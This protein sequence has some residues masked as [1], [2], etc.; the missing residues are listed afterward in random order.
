MPVTPT[1]P[2]VYIQEIDSGSRVVTGVPTSI[3]AFVGRAE[4]GAANEP[5]TV[6]DYGDFETTFGGLTIDM[7][8][9]YAVKDFFENGGSQAIVIRVCAG[10][11]LEA[12]ASLDFAT[13]DPNYTLTARVKGA[14]GNSLKLKIDTVKNPDATLPATYHAT[15]SLG[16]MTLA[17]TKNAPP[18]DGSKADDGPGL[19]PFAIPMWLTDQNDLIST[20]GSIAPEALPDVIK[21]N[22][23]QDLTFTGG[24]DDVGGTPAKF[25]AGEL[26]LDAMKG[27][28]V[29]ELELSLTTGSDPKQFVLTADHPILTAPIQLTFASWDELKKKL[30]DTTVLSLATP[31]SVALPF[32]PPTI[33]LPGAAATPA[34]APA[35]PGKSITLTRIPDGQGASKS[36]LVVGMGELVL[37]S[38]SPGAW[39]NSYGVYFDKKNITLD[40]ALRYADYGI[41][42]SIDD[43]WNVNVVEVKGGKPHPVAETIG[44]CYL[45]PQDAPC[46]ID[47]MLARQSSYLRSAPPI[48]A[49]AAV[50]LLID[51]TQVG[52]LMNDGKTKYGMLASGSDGE[53]LTTDIVIGSDRERT[54]IYALDKA[55]IF[56]I[57]VIPPDP[58][59]GGDQDMRVIYQAAAN[60]CANHRAIL[61]ADPLDAWNFKAK[62]RQFDQISPADFN[63]E[64]IADR[65]S[66][67]T[68]FPRVKK[69]DPL[70]GNRE[71]VFSASGM[72]AGVF[73]ATDARRG[74]WK[75]PAGVEAVLNGV[76]ALEWK[77]TDMQSGVLNALGINVL[78]DFPVIGKVVWGSRTLAGADVM[79][80]DYKYLPARR[81]TDYIEESLLRN[82]RWAVFEPNNESLWA[83]MRL[84]IGAFMS[85]LARQGAFYDYYV[86]CDGSTTTANDINLGKCNA[87]VAFAP[88][89][90]DEFIILTIQQLALKPAA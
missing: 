46:R 31:P 55:D 27:S 86:R 40:V 61:I 89:K 44:P 53:S 65:R 26:E 79:S 48:S 80:D 38:P 2:G 5:I 21:A 37:T 14:I 39:G 50:N 64:A 17:T 42:A 56:N 30:A 58:M 74:V 83:T 49:P 28:W 8:M 35:F 34:A 13:A 15:L 7:P 19:T 32:A 88:V 54:G 90:P 85:D 57:M 41:P 84:S 76:T 45:G 66:V 75:A 29:D 23:D 22:G 72:I 67:F 43:F 71:M 33:A 82:T 12:A 63:I 10:P 60:Y 1:Y 87:I 25:K 70:R 6:F 4:R 68:Y 24:A 47:H 77:L 20:S 52:V 3:T 59:L 62:R 81:L 11:R 9:T 18:T 78:R 73:A 69:S 16:S 36:I 51:P